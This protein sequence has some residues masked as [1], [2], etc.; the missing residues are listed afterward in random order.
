MHC[1]RGRDDAAQIAHFQSRQVSG[2]SGLGLAECPLSTHCGHS[3]SIYRHPMGKS[4]A[5]YRANGRLLVAPMVRSTNGL[6]LEIDPK[7]LG[8]C[9][10]EE[11]VEAAIASALA[12]SE[13]IVPH[14][15]QSEWKGFFNP[16]LK[17]AGVRSYKSFMATARS[18][19]VDEE[20]GVLIVTPNRNLGAKEG[21]EP[22]VADRQ[23]LPDLSATAKAV[24][25]LL[26]HS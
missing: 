18:L 5:V 21:F 20:C 3:I 19:S 24:L 6:G 1:E 9:P 10:D 8:E 16:F 14:P 13:R 4:V 2:C 23:T 15:E 7:D 22:I 11:S 26:P 25:E 12:Q 17:A